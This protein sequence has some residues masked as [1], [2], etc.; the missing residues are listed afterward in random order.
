[1]SQSI[2]WDDT[3]VGWVYN[4]GM[5]GDLLNEMLDDEDEESGK[6]S[7]EAEP[8]N[9]G[10]RELCWWCGRRTEVRALFTGT[11]RICSSCNK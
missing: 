1:M 2:T 7:E 3:A 11:C 8:E 10:N 6:P 9:N 4:T 5:W